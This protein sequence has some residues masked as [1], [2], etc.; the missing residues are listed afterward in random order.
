MT[1]TCASPTGEITG[2][3]QENVG[4]TE[5]IFAVCGVPDAKKGERLVVLHSNMDK[6]PSDLCDALQERGIPNLWIPSSNCFFAVD[7]IPV[8]A[9]GKVDLQK[10][11]QTAA[12]LAG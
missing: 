10:V 7:E 4:A 8:L 6:P 2:A 12:N 9:T 5:Q 3:L 1:G 11:K